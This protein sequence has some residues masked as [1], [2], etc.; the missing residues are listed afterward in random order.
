MI[1]IYSDVHRSHFGQS[2]LINGQ[3]HPSFEC[4]SRAEKILDSIVQSNL[5]VVQPPEDFGLEPIFK[6]HDQKYLFFLK[7]AWKRWVDEGNT[8]DLL[9]LVSPINLDRSGGVSSGNIL[10][11]MGWYS[12]D[13]VTPVTSGSW[14]AAYA[15]AQVALTAQKNVEGGSPS[16]FALCRP[17][18]HHA[19]ANYMAGFCYLNNAAIAAQA[20][21]DGG[22]KRV[23]ILD[24]DYHH[25]NGTQ[26]IFYKR[27]DVQFISIHGDPSFEYP[28]YMGSAD[29][30]GEGDGVGFNYNYPLP[31]AS[32]WSV[33]SSA[34]DKA[35]KEIEAYSPDFLVISLGVDTFKDD[36]ISQFVLES[37]DFTRMG[38]AIG[39]IKIPTLFIQEGGY[40]VGD[41]GLNVANVLKGFESVSV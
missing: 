18:G 28:F 27:N 40:A 11:E 17:P 39:G 13:T 2:E 14:H 20:F 6:V 26:D 25:G 15:S 22:A 16:A 41:I 5:G 33:W 34:L 36:P 19:G 12:F 29:E 31:S 21:L 38:K 10:A 8:F 7:E 24:V 32:G 23:T 30:R 9:S 3:F 1:T 37:D 4:P 35:I